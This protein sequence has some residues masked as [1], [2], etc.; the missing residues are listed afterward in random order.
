MADADRCLDHKVHRAW[1]AMMPQ[2]WLKWR[3]W[4]VEHAIGIVIA[5][6]VIYIMFLLSDRTP[7]FTLYG[8]KIEP[9]VLHVGDS[10]EITWRA[11]YRGSDC[12][13]TTQR[14]TVSDVDQGLTPE[15]TRERRGVFHPDPDNP[16]VGT[17][18]TPMYVVPIVQPGSAR[19]RVTQFYYCNWLQKLLQRWPIIQES[20]W[21]TYEVLP[22]PSAERAK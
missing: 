3:E 6:F 2:N 15:L 22:G 7:P 8:G 19:Y 9:S 14:E 21:I 20:P 1:K 17:I 13:G 10:A 11:R 16:D 5:V 18:T 12:D 4:G